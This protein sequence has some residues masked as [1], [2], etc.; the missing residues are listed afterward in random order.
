MK[1]KLRAGAYICTNILLL[2]F[3]I[4]CGQDDDGATPQPDP[5]DDPQP[6]H[7][8]TLVT[9]PEDFDDIQQAID[10]A[11]DGDTIV[12]EP[13]TYE[14]NIDFIGKKILLTSLFYIEHDISYISSTIIKVSEGSVV[15][16]MSNES[17]DAILQGFT[18]TGGTGEVY[19]RPNGNIT[20]GGGGVLGLNSSP[21]IRYNIIEDNEATDVSGEN[22]FAGGGGI[23]LELGTPVVHNNV[24]RNNRGGFAGGVFLDA[25][26]AMF[27]NNLIVNNSATKNEF[28]GGGGLYLDYVLVGSNGNK[29]ANNTITD[30]H[31]VGEGGGLVL[32]GA[33]VFANLEFTNNIIYN[34]EGAEVLSRNG[35]SNSNFLPSYCIIEGG[36]ETGNNIQDV[37]P[38]LVDESYI[39][40]NDS[41]CIDN[42]NPDASYNDKNDGENVMAPCLGELRNDIGAT[43]GP[44]AKLIL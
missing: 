34:N 27:T 19:T 35:A 25:T 24:I 3:I 22:P 37:D 41:P 7:L 28:A 31:S 30:N 36:F 20:R 10:Q 17:N 39:L 18:I 40:K 29:I 11:I 33:T 26:A 32:A 14:E 43:G 16:F 15:R 4:A 12:V 42:G 5:K 21:T 38:G 6:E 44:N 8:A 1:S 9:V 2:F 13:G 23:R